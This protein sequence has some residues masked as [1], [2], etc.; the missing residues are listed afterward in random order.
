M[1]Y[2]DYLGRRGLDRFGKALE[3]DTPEKPIRQTRKL[4]NWTI[5]IW[6]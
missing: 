5:F 1:T 6:A 4:F 3:Q 2:E